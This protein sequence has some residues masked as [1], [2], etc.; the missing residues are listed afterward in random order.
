MKKHIAPLAMIAVYYADIHSNIAY[1]RTSLALTEF[2]LWWFLH[3]ILLL[4]FPL[5]IAN[6]IYFSLD[7]VKTALRV[8]CGFLHIFWEYYGFTSANIQVV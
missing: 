3:Y 2:Y 1:Y 8:F 5:L 6:Y 4:F 7:R